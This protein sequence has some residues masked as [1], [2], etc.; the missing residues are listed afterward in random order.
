MH[1]SLHQTVD[2]DLHTHAVRSDFHTRRRWGR[3][4]YL[5]A[6]IPLAIEMGKRL[7][8]IRVRIGCRLPIH[9]LGK[10]N[11]ESVRPCGDLFDL[12][13]NLASP[14]E[15]LHGV[16]LGAS[17][18]P[19][20]VRAAGDQIPLGSKLNGQQSSIKPFTKRIAGAL[21]YA[22]DQLGRRSHNYAQAEICHEDLILKRSK[23]PFSPIDHEPGNR[24]AHS[25]V[26]KHNSVRHQFLDTFAF[27]FH[28]RWSIRNHGC[29]SKFRS[30]VVPI[31]ADRVP[32][33]ATLLQHFQ[34]ARS[35]PWPLAF[36]VKHLAVF[37]GANSARAADSAAHRNRF[38]FGC[39][40]QTPSSKGCIRVVRLGKAKRNPDISFII[41]F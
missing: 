3:L 34:R 14:I 32:H 40:F 27:D 21:P 17:H 38:A 6:A 22:V 41:R 26:W 13:R 5:R 7:Q 10:F 8:L 15:T 30:Q 20:A 18:W 28:S 36:R 11:I 31:E 33:K 35:V 24:T 16:S 9:R 12:K 39:N 19:T 2:R 29:W 25:F 23:L 1:V 4:I 37:V